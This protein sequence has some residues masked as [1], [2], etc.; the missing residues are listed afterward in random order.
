MSQIH[1]DLCPELSTIFLR[2]SSY[3]QHSI[4][5]AVAKPA[6]NETTADAAEVN[7]VD[8]LPRELNV[9]LP[10]VCEALVLLAQCISSM[11][12]QSVDMAAEERAGESLQAIVNRQC[13]VE[14]DGT[15]Q[16]TVESIVGKH[17]FMYLR[18]SR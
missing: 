11:T 3:A 5:R 15:V 17:V 8:A 12:L 16:G 7:G 4:E 10:Q 1:T 13:H 6:V 18:S 2:L 14:P 9:L